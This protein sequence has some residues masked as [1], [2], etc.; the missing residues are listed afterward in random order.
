MNITNRELCAEAYHL[1][2]NI[3]FQLIQFLL[4]IFHI[5]A[6]IL[7]L[8]VCTNIFIRKLFHIN[9]RILLTNLFA[10][11]LFQSLVTI[12]RSSN[13]IYRMISYKDHCSFLEESVKCSVLSDFGSAP[14]K[15]LR[16]AFVA[17]TVERFIAMC[18]YQQYEKWKYPIALTFLP[19]T[20]VEIPFVIKHIVLTLSQ[21]ENIYQNY[22]FSVIDKVMF[23]SYLAFHIPL[24]IAILFLLLITRII[25]K[26]KMKL[27]LGIPMGTLSSRYQ[28]RE[29]MKTS[30][31]M[32]IATIMYIIT[33]ILNLS[34]SFIVMYLPTT[35]F[36]HSL[37]YEEITNFPIVIFVISLSILFIVRVEY[38][39]NKI[40]KCKCGKKLIINDIHDKIFLA[41]A[42]ICFV[43]FSRSLNAENIR[44]NIKKN[45]LSMVNEVFAE[46]N[47]DVF[48]KMS[49]RRRTRK[50]DISMPINFEHRYHAGFD[51]VT[52]QYHGLPKQWQAIIGITPN[53]RGRPRPMID[54]SCI[55][56]MEI[57]EIKTV[58]RGD[59]P[60][61]NQKE[62]NFDSVST[63]NKLQKNH[64]ELQ[65]GAQ[66]DLTRVVCT[67]ETWTH[68]PQSSLS[69]SLYNRQPTCHV[70]QHLSHKFQSPSPVEM[71]FQRVS[72]LQNGILQPVHLKQNSSYSTQCE[73]ANVVEV[74]PENYT[75]SQQSNCLYNN[76][77]QVR[78]NPA[79][80]TLPH[81]EASAYRPN[82]SAIHNNVRWKGEESNNRLS[83]EE[84][85]AALKMVVL[86]GDPRA[87]L[88]N[89]VKIGEGSTGTVVTAHQISTG[90][91]IAVKKMNI[92]K[93]QRRELLF[94]EVLIMRDYEHPNIVE[95]YGSYL[96][97]D[98]LWVLMEY[99]EGGA[100]TDIITQMRI[101]ESIIAAICV[102]CLKALEY[103]HSKGVVHRDI[104]SDS[105]LLTKNGVAKISDFGFCG[106]LSVDIPQRRSLVGT[107]YW[108]SPEVISRLPYGTE[109]DIWSL[110][111]MV[112]E[113]VQGEPP[114]FNV[115]PLQAMK[116]IR[117]NA[118]PKINET[119]N[120][121]PELASFIS[122]MLV[123][124]VRQRATASRLLNHEFLK[125]ACD[126]SIICSLMNISR[127]A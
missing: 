5:M 70:Q 82:N 122:Q 78:M 86:S 116:I 49:I 39:R 38:M 107:P 15:C 59:L 127:N 41:I 3:F 52:G 45:S 118:P 57:A 35:N 40:I 55:T 68:L 110:G 63:N 46:T 96:V 58:V 74:Y 105:I 28:I 97:G 7:I 76:A 42:I 17:I 44:Q 19:L 26:R 37:I 54:P 6:V 23:N 94:N 8:Y 62:I 22:C 114:L 124:D 87:D 89:Y 115:Q 112:I 43:C 99:M 69:A 71:N 80:S 88:T 100:L 77:L 29:N 30:K 102:Q 32:F 106:Q 123:R 16:Y 60:Q 21:S 72:T 64:A 90:M 4:V 47:I 83:Q 95:M 13:F 25:S 34:I 1:Q 101:D 51:P 9:L 93:Q 31:T 53:R 73:L 113:M 104:K 48:K 108:M 66:N 33:S 65:N 81:N 20:W 98:E 61:P 18:C 50:V 103:L 75:M 92:L 91:K 56:P 120:V 119:V 126:P 84:F 85:R 27:R 11:L 111:I 109:A 36:S 24:L 79:P 14:L 67:S 121:S 10:L 125:K 2:T 12:F 117:D